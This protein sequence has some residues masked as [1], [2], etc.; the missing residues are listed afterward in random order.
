VLRDAGCPA[1]LAAQ[2]YIEDQAQ[3]V[4]HQGHQGQPV[5]SGLGSHALNLS[6]RRGM[7]PFYGRPG[8]SS[9]RLASL[10]QM[11]A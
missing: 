8:R 10:D 6:G 11:F 2:N 1:P 5:Q 7:Q 3:M 4:R 9:T